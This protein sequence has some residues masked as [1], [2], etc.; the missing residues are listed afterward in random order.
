MTRV[1]HLPFALAA[2]A[3]VGC[4]NDLDP[5]WKIK[6]FRVFGVRIDNVSRAGATPA[7]PDAT[8]ASPGER[9]ALTLAY[10]DPST[11]PRAVQVVWIIG[12][13]ASR[14]G[15]TIGFDPTTADILMGGAEQSYTVPMRAYGVDPQ[16]RARLQA[17]AF[18]CAG[19][20]VGFD[21][22]TRQPTCT[23]TG[24]ESVL[25]TR[26]LVV[27]TAET[28]PINHNPGLT[29][30]VLYLNGDT[31]R[32]VPLTVEGD[33]RVP[34]CT[35]SDECPQHVI[36][37]TVRDGSRET[38]T[39]RNTAGDPVVQPERLQFGYF[40]T[41]GEM[42]LT[43]YV[44]TAGRPSGPVRNKWSAPRTPGTVRMLFSAQDTRGGF[45]WIERR[46]TVE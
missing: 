42:D 30:A 4:G 17:L 41:D 37:L 43:F 27:R 44:D 18:A 32:P 29:G 39:A 13:Q 28:D 34:R 40:V 24:A 22:T 3:A 2:L 15:N 45:T 19:G 25:I 23:G 26:S 16:G 11:T 46:V 21:A 1:K 38:Y 36:E 7:N 9:V 20:T 5:A 33:A 31:T 6:T 12:A 8:E 14:M 35:A 10:V